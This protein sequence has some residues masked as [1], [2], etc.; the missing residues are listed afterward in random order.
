MDNSDPAWQ[1][2]YVPGPAYG[3]AKPAATGYSPPQA[4]PSQPQGP[5][6]H[7]YRSSYHKPQQAQQAQQRPLPQQQPRPQVRSSPPPKRKVEC[8]STLGVDRNASSDE[9]K[10]AFRRAAMK[11]HPDKGGDEA[12]FKDVCAAYE[13]LSDPQKRRLYDQYGDVDV[14]GRTAELPKSPRKFLWIDVALD[15]LYAGAQTDVSF[16]RVRMCSDCEARGVKQGE[17]VGTRCEDCNGIGVCVYVIRDGYNT[18]KQRGPCETCSGT[19]KIFTVKDLC[20]K[21]NGHGTIEETSE[22]RVVIKPGMRNDDYILFRGEGDHLVGTN[23]GDVVVFV[24]ECQ[25]PRFFRVGDDLYLDQPISLVDALCGCK[26]SFRHMD[27]K[28]I[29]YTT[30][31]GVTLRSGDVKCVFGHGMPILESE[32]QRSGDLY[33]RL[34]LQI[35]ATL[36]EDQVKGIEEALCPGGRS[37]PSDAAVVEM[38]DWDESAARHGGGAS[39]PQFDAAW[40]RQQQQQHE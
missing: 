16:S 35:P 31:P 10:R 17:S 26:L 18:Q 39:P 27:G 1:Y 6:H 23:A 36:T 29:V 3:A 11:H 33:L 13:V 8:Y 2:E 21:C 25:H 37:V 28:A 20:E 12:L 24:R 34:I 22:L 4:Q 15:A 32:G 40:R 19:G 7:Q 38:A 14:A 30:P 5:H 9:I